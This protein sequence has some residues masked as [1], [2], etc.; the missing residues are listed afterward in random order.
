MAQNKKHISSENITEWLS[1]TGFL[2]PRNEIELARFEKIH[3]DK[4]YGLT[5]REL[6]PERIING[7]PFEKKN[8]PLVSDVAKKDFSEYRMAARNGNELP[9][10]IMDKIKKNQSKPKSDG[11]ET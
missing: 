6:D 5:G 3:G 11:P 7:L 10:H 1:S 9:K 2:V 4:D 8:I